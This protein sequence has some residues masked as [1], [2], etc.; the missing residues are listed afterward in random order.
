MVLIEDS[1]ERLHLV[2]VTSL[3]CYFWRFGRQKEPMTLCRLHNHLQMSAH[4]D[5]R[6]RQLKMSVADSFM[7]FRDY[8]LHHRSGSFPRN[9]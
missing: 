1:D 2:E 5:A 8:T 9:F 3:G 7:E 4:T 6:N